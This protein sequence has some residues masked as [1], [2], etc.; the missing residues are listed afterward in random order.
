MLCCDVT[1]RWSLSP[2]PDAFIAELVARGE[3]DTATWL[4]G[5]GMVGW[6]GGGVMLTVI[7]MVVGLYECLFGSQS[8]SQEA[9]AHRGAPLAKK[10]QAEA[11]RH[12]LVMSW[13]RSL[14]LYA[15][16]PHST[17]TFLLAAM[18]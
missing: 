7:L 9:L 18:A 2:G 11:L 12:G 1:H 13:G 4:V 3:A 10:G 8:D 16:A 14:F 15:C 6:R 5:G 17:C